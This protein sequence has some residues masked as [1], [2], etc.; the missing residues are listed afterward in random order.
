MHSSFSCLQYTNASSARSRR[1]M[2]SMLR[3]RTLGNAR[4]YLRKYCAV[5]AAVVAQGPPPAPCIVALGRTSAEP[6]RVPFAHIP[7]RHSDLPAWGDLQPFLDVPVDVD[8]DCPA[9]SG[10]ADVPLEAVKRTYHP[11]VIQKKRKHGFLHR[12]STTAGRRV[13]ARRARKG[14]KYVSV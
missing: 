6:S 9:G 10:Q 8:V 13:L 3:F 2:A 7:A 5:A 4:S 14:R 12:N 11:H 1:Q